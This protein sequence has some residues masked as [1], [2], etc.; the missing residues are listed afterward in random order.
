MLV[1]VIS[2]SNYLLLSIHLSIQVAGMY[3]LDLVRFQIWVHFHE[4]RNYHFS[5]KDLLYIVVCVCV[6]AHAC[7]CLCDF[8]CTG[9]YLYPQGPE[10]IRSFGTRITGGYMRYLKLELNIRWRW[11]LTT[12]PSLHPQGKDYWLCWTTNVSRN[13]LMDN[14]FLLLK[15]EIIF[16]I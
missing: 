12:E 7:M 4:I 6:C 8:M 11:F 10:H 15:H 16:L 9:A 14:F 13:F 1:G 2:V 5:I 3:Q